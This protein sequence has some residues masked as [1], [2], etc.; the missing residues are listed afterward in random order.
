MKWESIAQWYADEKNRKM[1]YLLGQL[2]HGSGRSVNDIYMDLD[3]MGVYLGG[4]GYVLLSFLLDDSKFEELHMPVDRGGLSAAILST[5]VSV[6]EQKCLGFFFPLDGVIFA[7]VTYP[8]ITGNTPDTE[9]I[10]LLLKRSCETIQKTFSEQFNHSMF[11]VVSELCFDIKELPDVYRR[12]M[13]YLKYAMLF[14]KYDVVSVGEWTESVTIDAVLKEMAFAK[15]IANSILYDDVQPKSSISGQIYDYLLSG[16]CP[17]QEYLFQKVYEFF[18]LLILALYEDEVSLNNVHISEFS[19]ELNSVKSEA[20]L[21]ALID[22]IYIRISVAGGEK[23][24]LSEKRIESVKQY[25]EKNMTDCN[26]SVRIIASAFGVSQPQLSTQFKKH[27]GINITDY[28][29][30]TRIGFIKELISDSDEPII[31]LYG[32]AGFISLS[33]FYRVFQKYEGISPGKLRSGLT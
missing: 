3:H 24:S 18:N 13:S 11:A 5:A 31:K 32:K 12:S 33:T 21:R 2:M 4:G 23:V 20:E 6:L 9:N 19:R 28:I 1:A 25:I 27:T 14:D 7:L 16:C 22:D 17:S 30:I 15:K 10:P 26:L 8:R 29:N